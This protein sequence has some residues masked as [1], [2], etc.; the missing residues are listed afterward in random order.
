MDKTQNE[1]SVIWEC[2]LSENKANRSMYLSESG[3]GYKAAWKALVS[4]RPDNKQ[5]LFCISPGILVSKMQRCAMQ[6]TMES[7]E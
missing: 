3:S 6:P 7:G 5:H 1:G 4:W 2:S